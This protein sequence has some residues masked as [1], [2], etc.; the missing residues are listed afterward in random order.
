MTN[1]DDLAAFAS[2]ARERSFTRAAAE[3]GV[4]TSALSHK[5]RTLEARL[6]VQL[7]VRTTRSVKPTEAGGQLLSTLEPALADVGRS[8]DA[9]V[10]ARAEPAGSI[11]ITTGRGGAMKVL[12]PM[13][14][15]FVQTHPAISVEV[16]VDEHFRDI[17]E[18]GFDGGIRLGRDIAPG[19]IS[20]RISP[21]ARSV[22]VASPAYIAARGRPLV[23]TDLHS[24]ACID[25][26]MET[27]GRLYAWEF[28]REGRK[29]SIKV[30]GRLC[31]NDSNLMIASALKGAGLTYVH[32]TMVEDQI[33]SG[34]LIS[35]LDDWCP[36]LP[37]FYF[38][39][40]RQYPKPALAAF[41]DALKAQSDRG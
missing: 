34:R 28:E 30:E 39:H 25:Y 12:A 6:G 11:R 1:L 35:V 21:P 24:H 27:S 38:Y 7:L 5:I 37:G 8:L 17:V 2:V 26:R 15:D 29:Q 13:L 19:M 9:L 14:A 32:E 4:S 10:A 16:I 31:F 23:P 18:D 20:F 22:V 40:A 36:P 41:I 33:A 3:R